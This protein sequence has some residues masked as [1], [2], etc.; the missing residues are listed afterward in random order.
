MQT[1]IIKF[2]QQLSIILCLT[3]AAVPLCSAETSFIEQFQTDPVINENLANRITRYYSEDISLPLEQQKTELFNIENQLDN[4]LN[5][6]SQN[7]TYWFIRGLQNRNIAAFYTESKNLQ[8]A[9]TYIK[10]K[11]N[12]Y[13]NAL[14]LSKKVKNSLSAAIYSTM[15]H[16]LPED[17]KIEA[18]KNEISQGGNGDN[19]SYYWYLH[20]SNIDQLQKAGR[21]DEAKT[22]YK[23][24]QNELR[25][26]GADVSIYNSLT[27]KI[28]TKTFNETAVT[29]PKNKNQPKTPKDQPKS[30]SQSKSLKND[31]PIK[32][33]M[34]Y[35]IIFSVTIF[36]IIIFV[37]VALY[38]RMQ[39]RKN[40]K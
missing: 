27:K 31:T 6:Y 18:T 37:I 3:I 24:M 35:I 25:L 39:K 30:E 20:W 11:D 33:D 13:K 40:I 36:S 5:K 22:A 4:V 9:K 21:E 15:K 29:K 8:L 34:K 12:A 16:G 26:S 7:A 1:L 38:E 19:E 28:Q 14:E 23:K 17:L 2:T 32:Y 10:S